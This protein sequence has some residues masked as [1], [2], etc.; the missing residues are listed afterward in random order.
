[1]PI[2]RYHI[3]FFS[4]EQAKQRPLLASSLEG[5]AVLL[6]RRSSNFAL[7]HSPICLSCRGGRWDT[8]DNRRYRESI[9]PVLGEI[10]A[11]ML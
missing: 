10:D 6:D 11:A 4:G 1:M 5:A 9:W 8:T 2:P 7:P 3:E